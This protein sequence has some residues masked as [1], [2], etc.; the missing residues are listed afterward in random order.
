MSNPQSQRQRVRPTDRARV[1][2]RQL[3]RVASVAGGI[4]FGW[5]LQLSLLTPYVQQLGIPHAWASIIWLCG[6]L[7]G[8][9]VT[10][11]RRSM[12]LAYSHYHDTVASQLLTRR[13]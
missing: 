4:Q 10:R 12:A 5:A 8:L 9:F 2:L 11:Y 7:S 1:S 13:L 3:F 6:P